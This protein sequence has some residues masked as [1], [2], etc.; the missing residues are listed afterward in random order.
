MIVTD[1]K[2]LKDICVPIASAEEEKEIVEQLE[3]ELEISGNN[4]FP[5]IG[6]AAPQIGIKKR[7]AIIR[8]DKTNTINLINSFIIRGDDTVVSEEGCLSLPGKTSKVKRFL[9]LQIKNNSFLNGSTKFAAYGLSAICIQHEMDHW[10]GILMLDKEISIYDN[11]GPNMSCPCKSGLKFKKC[12]RDK[13]NQGSKLR[14]E[15]GQDYG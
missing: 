7:V 8:V 15:R 11:I 9:N 10:E 2:D 6:L 3:K 1:I 13:V 4:G 5:G 14:G 12:C